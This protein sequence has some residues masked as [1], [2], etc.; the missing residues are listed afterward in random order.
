MVI[1]HPCYSQSFN[2]GNFVTFHP[3]TRSC[4]GHELRILYFLWESYYDMSVPCILVF[5]SQDSYCKIT[6]FLKIFCTYF[7]QKELGI[8]GFECLGNWYCY[9]LL[10]FFVSYVNSCCG[11]TSH[12]LVQFCMSV[13]NSCQNA[14]KGFA[15]KGWPDTQFCDYSITF[16]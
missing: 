12:H 9:I 8:R 4:V 6:H 16:V 5:V 1:S 7:L 10:K 13:V 15:I 3:F 11:S 2:K 14:R